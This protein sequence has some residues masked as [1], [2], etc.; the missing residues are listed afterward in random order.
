LAR[1]SSGLPTTFTP[2]NQ[3]AFAGVGTA[4]GSLRL[5]SATI[6]GS[7]KNSSRTDNLDLQLDL[8]GFPTLPAGGYTGV[9]NLRVI[10]Q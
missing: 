7:N 2:I 9:L 10:T 6:N 8:V 1:M 3:N 5:Y 4:G